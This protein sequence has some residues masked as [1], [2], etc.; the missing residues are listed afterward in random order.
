MK[1]TIL[2]QNKEII[3]NLIKCSQEPQQKYLGQLELRLYQTADIQSETDILNMYRDIEFCDIC[4]LDIGSQ[5]NHSLLFNIISACRECKGIILPADF[6]GCVGSLLNLGMLTI[7]DITSINPQL[8]ALSNYKFM[9]GM[10]QDIEAHGS[11]PLG[12]LR[13][14]KNYIAV[15]SYIEAGTSEDMSQLLQLLAEEYFNDRYKRK[16]VS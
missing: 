15:C 8:D 6:Q 2:S 5:E 13:D 16:Y 7:K 3:E 1:L 10:L 9:L 12:R 11:I 4:I 14:F